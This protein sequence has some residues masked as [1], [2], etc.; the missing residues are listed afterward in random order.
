MAIWPTTI[1]INYIG[2]VSGQNVAS[3]RLYAEEGR[4]MAA[5]NGIIGR[6]SPA[7]KAAVVAVGG[8]LT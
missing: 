2:N 6:P 3:L 5:G 1:N 8:A 4:L 7:T